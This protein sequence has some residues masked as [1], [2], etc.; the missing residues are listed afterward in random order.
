[1]TRSRYPAGEFAVLKSVR[2]LSAELVTA[3]LLIPIMKVGAVAAVF[4]VVSN[5][6]LIGI[7]SLAGGSDGMNNRRP[8]EA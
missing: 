7:L 3:V 5:G 8:W 2:S 6:A 1:M 4:V